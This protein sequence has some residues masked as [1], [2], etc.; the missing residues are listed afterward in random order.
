MRAFGIVSVLLFT[1]CVN[2]GR[3]AEPV[4]VIIPCPSSP[5]VS[6]CDVG[7]HPLPET[8]REALQDRERILVEAHDCERAVRVWEAGYSVCA[9]D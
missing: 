7:E 5:P 1:G 6:S 3:Q 2:F 9:V 8:L 4:T